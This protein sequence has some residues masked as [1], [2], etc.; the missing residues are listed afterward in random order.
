LAPQITAELPWPQASLA[1][2]TRLLAAQRSA[3]EATIQKLQH[4]GSTVIEVQQLSSTESSPFNAYLPAKEQLHKYKLVGKDSF[5]SKM[6]ATDSL[7]SSQTVQGLDA[8]LTHLN[9]DR[10][11][12]G[13]FNLF[14]FSTYFVPKC[15]VVTARPADLLRYAL[16]TKLAFVGS[17]A[18]QQTKS[19]LTE[20]ATAKIPYSVVGDRILAPGLAASWPGVK[21]IPLESKSLVQGYRIQVGAKAGSFTIIE[22][23]PDVAKLA[24]LAKWNSATQNFFSQGF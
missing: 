12:I 15:E 24:S 3:L 13:G 10:C 14:D 21:S 1:Q 23:S 5:G 11:S 18:Y 19:Q 20:L 8:V 9:A 7:P 17:D 4:S 22:T 2:A 16:I 6:Y